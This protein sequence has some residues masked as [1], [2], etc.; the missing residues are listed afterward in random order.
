[1]ANLK[2]SGCVRRLVP[3]LVI[4]AFVF[5]SG[6]QAFA[7]DVATSGLRMKARVK[8]LRELRDQNVVRQ[9]SDYSCG[10]AG[11]STLLSYELRDPISEREIMNQIFKFV[12]IKKVQER[13]GFSL[14]D[15]KR[16]AEA[17]GY[18]VTG[19]KMDLD[20]L[21]E[22]KRPVLVPIKFKNYRHFVIVKAVRG[23]KVFV[24]DPAMGNMIV[25]AGW[26]K[27]IWQ[28]GIGMVIENPKRTA[29]ASKRWPSLLRLK[30]TD[31]VYVEE[32][33]LNPSLDVSAIRTAVYP[34]EFA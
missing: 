14:L 30:E 19:Y 9:T 23:R 33:K 2:R 21:R 5:S 22:L 29:A 7:L 3:G 4:A 20:Y 6:A 34:T 24:A 27:R 32:E 11:L 26:F 13:R 10:A 25:N 1:M 31:E 17:R 18:K 16:F 12:N 28:D 15:L 8:S